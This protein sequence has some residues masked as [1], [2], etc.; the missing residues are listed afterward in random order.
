MILSRF[1]KPK[2]QHADPEARQ[3][4][5]QQLDR[6]DPALAALVRADHDPAVRRTA[7]QQLI[8]LDLLAERMR[9]DDDPATRDA[10]QDRYRA[11]LAGEVADGPPLAVRLTRLEGELRSEDLLFLL[12]HAREAALRLQLLG[13][14]RDPALLVE[15]ATGDPAFEVQAAALAR[16]HEPDQLEQV[17][18]LSRNRNK[19][20][21]R[22]A[23]ERLDNYRETARRLAEATAL[24]EA[25]E[26]IANDPEASPRNTRYQTLLRQWEALDDPD[27]AL[28]ERVARARERVQAR[29]QAISAEQA[30]RRQL[31]DALVHAL[32]RLNQK[33]D[34]D[35]EAG[36]ILDGVRARL[37][38]DPA[39]QTPAAERE[40]RAR[41]VQQLEER[42]RLLRRNRERVVRLQKLLAEAER[43][44]TG[45]RPVQEAGLEKLRRRWSALEQPESA[46]LAET[47][48][49]QWAD[50]AGRWQRRLETQ[51]AQREQ[52][53]VELQQLLETL[54]REVAEGEV[55]QASEHQARLRA[56]FRDDQ[57][58]PG[59]R[60]GLESR[61]QALNKTLGELRDWRRWGTHQA[62]DH[63]C[64]A[65]EALATEETLE[66]PERARRVQALRANWQRLDRNE[67]AASRAAWEHFNAACERAYQP[68]IEYFEAQ[69]R[70]RAVNL[71]Q[72]ET[73]CAELEQL[74]ADTD[75]EAVPDWRAVDRFVHDRQQRWRQLG[76]VDRAARKAI[77]KR[78]NAIRKQL[79]PILDR[80][81]DQDLRRRRALIQR[82]EALVEHPDLREAI[83]Q[84][85]QAQAEWSPTI[86]ASRREEQT[87]WKT[88]R[89]ACDA[90]FARRQAE[91]QAQDQE[92]QTNLAAKEALIQEVEGLS[93]AAEDLAR[94]RGRLQE[95]RGEWGRIG[96][97]PSSAYPAIDRRLERVQEGF[98]ERQRMIARERD[99][100]ALRSLWQRHRLCAE[101]EALLEQPQAEATPRISAARQEWG[102]LERVKPSLGEA[103]RRRFQRV[104]QALEGE[105]EGET[106]V[107][108][109]RANLDPRQ[110]L[111]LRMEILAGAE[112]PPEF[113]QA[114]MA[115]QVQRL[116]ASLGG[117]EAA[118]QRPEEESEQVQEQWCLLGLLPV[119]AHQRLESRF[120]AALAVQRQHRPA[121]ETAAG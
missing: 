16:L 78:F 58:P 66:P 14:V 59:A 96:P 113:A 43:Q 106:L 10:A 64:E 22:Q 110:E 98:E 104:C 12:R 108:E 13:R 55:K 18:R 119:E 95:I 74:H 8:D 86:L 4:A 82:V 5:V 116:S 97:V 20:I 38:Q 117:G 69:A 31:H 34:L 77:D 30:E 32:D 27:A 87:L 29:H 80:Q 79:D 3:R 111:C 2:W 47:L 112:T 85:K 6:H 93:A 48:Q 91:Q 17:A 44:L 63:L 35:P 45:K 28:A 1:F 92:R 88:F 61:V 49:Q 67:G 73:L 89:G 62:R 42:E 76:P 53:L 25:L 68:C 121:S 24:C 75:W 71:Q 19:R 21:Y 26:V 9:A 72:R 51:A 36:Q 120:Q 102:T 57:L 115:Y 70:E 83:D 109:L 15:L 50:L 105:A 100:Q 54:E 99:Q 46:V 81:R 33:L 11:L 39:D 7:L 41:L 52:N 23:Q 65:A 107:A 114:R 84:A 101:L 90:I 40:T 37:A 56:L 118:R 94:S 60:R 103:I